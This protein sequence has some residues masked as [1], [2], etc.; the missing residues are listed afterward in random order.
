MFTLVVMS[1]HTCIIQVPGRNLLTP[2]RNLLTPGRNL[3]TQLKKGVNKIKE[4]NCG[5]VS[6]ATQTRSA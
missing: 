5:N 1:S 6:L 2:G 4:F 3:L